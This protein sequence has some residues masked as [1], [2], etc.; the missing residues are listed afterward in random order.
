MTPRSGASASRRP[1]RGFTLSSFTSPRCFSV[2]AAIAVSQSFDHGRVDSAKKARASLLK[3]L[4]PIG[5]SRRLVVG[6]QT[7]RVFR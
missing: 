6:R 5:L 3:I 7:D 1:S 4:S 2:A